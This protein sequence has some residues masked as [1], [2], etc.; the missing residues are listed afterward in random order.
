MAH[1]VGEEVLESIRKELVKWWYPPK[2]PQYK[3]EIYTPQ[4]T[5]SGCVWNKIGTRSHR[6]IN[7][8]YLDTNIKNKLI[9]GLNKFFKSAD[10]YDMAGVTYKRVHLFHGCPGSGKTSTVIAMASTF[11]YNIAKFTITS[12]IDSSQFESLFRTVPQNTFVLIEDVDALFSGRKAEQRVDFSTMLN[13]MD[14]IATTRGL[15]V[16]MTTNHLTRLDEA[17]RR[18][19]RVDCCIEFKLPG[20]EELAQ[21]LDTIGSKYKSEHTEFLDKYGDDLTIA[22]LQKHLFNCIIDERDSILSSPFDDE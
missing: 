21:A 8:I 22:Q 3:L 5:L 9:N 20:R 4:L 6:S 16:F 19:G 1:G 7:T 18:P 11:K 14:G 2:Q 17:L 13:C 15:I 10:L 12:S